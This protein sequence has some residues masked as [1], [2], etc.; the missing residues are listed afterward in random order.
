MLSRGIASQAIIRA[1][2]FDK[3]AH[4]LTLGNDLVTLAP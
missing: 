2:F 4:F 3:Q 1:I